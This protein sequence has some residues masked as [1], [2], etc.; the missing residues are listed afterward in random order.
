MPRAAVILAMALVTACAQGAPTTTTLRS[1]ATTATT[2]PPAPTTTEIP[3]PGCPDAGQLTEGGQV[4]RINQDLS[5]TSTIGAIT[6]V[7][8]AGCETFRIAFETSEGAPS[9]TPPS[10][11]VDYLDPAPILRVRLDVDST[12]V[13]D[14]LVETALVERLYVVRALD[15]GM[16]IDFHLAAAAQARVEIE[17]SPAVVQLDLQ[18]G[19]VQ[20]PTGA[21]VSEKAVVVSPLDGATVDQTVAISGYARAFEA[22]VVVIATS[23]GRVV[24]RTNTTA[25]DWLETWGEFTAEVTLEQGTVAIFAGDESP[26]DGSLEGVTFTVTIR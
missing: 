19:I 9:T 16:F 5:D 11:T 23:G 4:G 10:L 18:P 12:V 13:T 17:T 8:E 2:Q 26:R 21:A 7:A 24:A 6:W 14:Q 22:N 1:P 20:H 25:A 15:G 3:T